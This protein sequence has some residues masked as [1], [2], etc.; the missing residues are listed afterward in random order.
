MDQFQL[1]RFTAMN[2]NRIF[3][4]SLVVFVAVVSLLIQ[5]LPVAAQRRSPTTVASTKAPSAP[6]CT[7]AW[8]GSVTYKRQQS[9]TDNK[10]IKRVSGRGED[11][12]NWE[13]K[14]DYQASVAVV[15]SP[16]KNG[17]S[18]GRATINHNFTSTETIEAVESNSCDRGKTWKDMRGTSKSQ[19]ATSGSATVAANVNVGV[20]SDNT[21][22]VS[23]GLPQISGTTKGSQTSSFSGQC[24]PKEGKTLTMPPTQTSI[25]GNS[26]T[27]DGKDQIDPANPNKISGSYTNSWQNVTETITWSLQKCGAPLRI[28]DLKFQDMKFPN[29]DDWQDIT[30]Q[31]GTIDGNWVKLK[32]KVL[33]ASGETKYAEISFKETYK[34][35]KWD[36][37]KP[38]MPLKDNTVSV[39]LEPGEERE[40]EAL[41]DTSG[42]A[43]YDDGR[44]RLVQRVKVEAWENNKL[45]D[46]MTKNLKIAPKPLVLV[47]GLWSSW[48][49]WETWQN[50]L[51]TTHSYDW[52]AFPVGEKPE[53]GLMNTGGEFLSTTPTNTIAQNAGE[54]E[55]YIKYAQED[56][57]AWHVD[58]VAH[59]MGGLISRYYISKL[60]PG[61][62]PDGRPKVAHLIMLGTPNM[63]SPCADVI[64]LAFQVAGKD[65]QAI[66]QLRPDNIAEFNKSN[67]NRK[68][69]N[70]SAL[71]GNPL[72]TMCKSIVWNDGVVSVPSAKWT[73]SDTAETKSVHTELTG[74][75]DFST[76]VKPRLAIGP[77]GDH[78]PASPEMPTTGHVVRAIP[79]NYGAA[80]NPLDLDPT[81][82]TEPVAKYVK[83]GPKQVMDVEI[84]VTAIKNL[85]ITFMADPLVTASL[86]NSSGTVV[87][88]NL[89]G[90]PESR[91]YFRS[92][93]IDQPIAPA[94]WKIRF[95]NTSDREVEVYAVVWSDATK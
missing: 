93:F 28:T 27:S 82:S 78:N 42:Y 60:M 17:S 29:W 44:P 36:G 95:E 14:Y 38:D 72:P 50:I 62:L 37:A 22:S 80:F 83:L 53:K 61:N 39:R 21:Y 16:E 77:R 8:T 35:D 75:S 74:T 68:G 54:L 58:I 9:Q 57:N 70:F 12:R 13:M 88:K 19:T 46:D 2:K 65:V 40:V 64:D 59:S 63:G 15:E 34:G 26:L 3:L 67:F 4:R 81:P 87:G 33:N 86:M 6:K 31:V 5:I 24:T 94:T 23:V 47:H 45:T 89:A 49:A 52:K 69:V 66:K 20:N 84:P 1:L 91:G 73:I 43:W 10:T 90:T 25:D 7:G 55:K 71:A 32:A 79:R 48:R 11:T 18:V 76:F 92:M 51:T 56:R 30:E 85:G 41:W